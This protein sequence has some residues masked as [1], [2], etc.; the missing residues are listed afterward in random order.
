MTSIEGHPD[1][2][3]LRARYEIAAEKP[4]V[5]LLD[6]LTM[7]C[8][9]YLAASPWIVGFM[10]GGDL[11]VNNLI[12]GVA[13][14]VLAL[15]LATAN[16]RTHGMAWVVPVMGAWTIVAPWVVLGGAVKGGTILSNVIVG[17]LI[18]LLGLG[19][20]SLQTVRR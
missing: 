7:L 1:I 15:G 17:A 19:A 18:V 10:G 4:A 2:A 3:E 8:G 16:G 13:V 12:T 6:G 14:A 5:H 9:L 11:R 20:M